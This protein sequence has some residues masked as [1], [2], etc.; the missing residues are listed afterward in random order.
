[1]VKFESL[2][3]G[4]LGL[5]L[6]ATIAL[7]ALPNVAFGSDV[8]YATQ[9]RDGGKISY[10][11]EP[12]ALNSYRV[13]SMVRAKASVMESSVIGKSPEDIENVSIATQR[14]SK[15]ESRQR[16]QIQAAVDAASSVHGVD[17]KLI[18]A[19]IK[20]ESA[21]N[22]LAVSP[23]GARGLMQ[24]M[25]GTASRYGVQDVNDPFQ[26]VLGGT[27]YLRDLIHL[28]GNRLDL[29]LAAYNAGE[30]AVIRFKHTIPPFRETQ[31]YV[32]SVLSEYRVP[33]AS[34]K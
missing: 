28:F 26:N 19:V 22:P 14:S 17:P 13:F 3:A 23:K 15:G 12:V 8:I 10:T 33:I 25:P 1:M 21:F 7:L 32:R 6:L 20:V 34:L 9:S 30:N 11:N 29:V 2:G 18:L 5:H 27:A 31:Q 24:L 16:N 4:S